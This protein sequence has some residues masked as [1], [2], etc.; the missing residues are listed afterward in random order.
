MNILLLT[1]LV[2]IFIILI[3]AIIWIMISQKQYGNYIQPGGTYKIGDT[4][5]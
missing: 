2:I 5:I 1:L 4:R 3:N